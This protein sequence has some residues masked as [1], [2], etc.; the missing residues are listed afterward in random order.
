MIFFFCGVLVD[1]RVVDL[2][3]PNERS[4]TIQAE[5]LSSKRSHRNNEFFEI[6]VFYVL[7]FEILV[8]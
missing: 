7:V 1:D 5:D 3:V 6:L 4:S 2:K 8:F